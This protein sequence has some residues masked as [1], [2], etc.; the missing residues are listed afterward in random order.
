[1]K[2]KLPLLSLNAWG[3]IGKT[4]CYSRNFKTSYVKRYSKP[5]DKCSPAQ[6]DQR[7]RFLVC[8][9]VWDDLSSMAKALWR[10]YLMPRAWCWN[11]PF[12]HTNLS[13]SYPC[14]ETP[15][16]PGVPYNRKSEWIVGLA[17][18]GITP[19]GTALLYIDEK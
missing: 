6:S 7:H 12:L 15:C 19:I 10:K 9:L 4:L 11:N 16:L 17:R 14:R 5:S 13:T 8:K 18:I 1:M 2:L 3:S